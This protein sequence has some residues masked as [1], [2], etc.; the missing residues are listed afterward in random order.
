MKSNGSYWLEMLNLA[1]SNWSKVTTL[2]TLKPLA[3]TY[4]TLLPLSQPVWTPTR[5]TMGCLNG[6][7]WLIWNPS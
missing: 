1:T 5:V 4:V 2:N 6:Q 3:P 7:A